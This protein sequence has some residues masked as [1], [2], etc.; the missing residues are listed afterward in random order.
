MTTTSAPPATASGW[1]RTVQ[2]ALALGIPAL[3]GLA[4]IVLFM[5]T[6]ETGPY[7]HA[8]DYWLAA[9]GVPLAVIGLLSALGVHRLQNGRDG[10]LGAAGTWL[11]A[12]ACVVL[13]IN[14]AASLMA[15]EDLQWGPVYVLGSFLMLVG[16]ALLSAGSWRTGVLPK[17]VL[18][19]W[20]PL[21]L[22]GSFLA[23]GPVPVLLA[24]LYVVLIVVLPRRAVA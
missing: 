19:V 14:C 12:L 13:G 17:W 20:P 18:A 22:L 10:K 23:V 1:L 5:H 7:Q 3:L 15:G 6:T 4:V 9:D 24:V 16:L 8:A 11:N 2:I 21:W